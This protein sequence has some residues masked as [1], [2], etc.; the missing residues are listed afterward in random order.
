MEMTNCVTAKLCLLRVSPLL[1]TSANQE[2]HSR[3]HAR[4]ER[5]T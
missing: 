5:L 4:R 3:H 1:T 2:L